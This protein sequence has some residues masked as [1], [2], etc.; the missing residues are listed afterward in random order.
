MMRRGSRDAAVAERVV[1]QG[2]PVPGRDGGSMPSKPTG[3]HTVR[4]SCARSAPPSAVGGVWLPPMPPGGSLQGVRPAGS[5]SGRSR[6]SRSSR[7]HRRR[8]TA[9]RRVRTQGA[10]R[11]ARELLAPVLESTCSVPVMTRRR[12]QARQRAP[13]TQPSVV[14]PGGVGQPSVAAG[15]PQRRRAADR[16]VD[17]CR[18]RRRRASAGKFGC[19]REAEQAA[20]P[21]VV[22]LRPEVGEHGGGR[23]VEAV[24][25]L[26]DAALL[27]D[28]H[29]PVR[30][31]ADRGRR[32]SPESTVSSTKPAGTDAAAPAGSTTPPTTGRPTASRATARTAWRHHRSTPS[33]Q[34]H[35]PCPSPGRSDIRRDRPVSPPRPVL[36]IATLSAKAAGC[37]RAQWYAPAGSGDRSGP[38]RLGH[39]EAEGLA[40]PVA[41]RDL[42]HGYAR[43]DPPPPGRVPERHAARHVPALV[44]R[45]A[46]QLEHLVLRNS[47]HRRQR[48]ADPS[49]GRRASRSTPRGRSSRPLGRAARTRTGRGARRR[50]GRRGDRPTP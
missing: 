19:E 37:E 18:A 23:V 29:P 41:V 30:R 42:V 24:E 33:R 27:G 47:E 11:V 5:R 9:R 8:R 38:E 34:A 15:A 31:E 39:L 4:T 43:R 12:L 16:R 46:E 21:E 17:A 44:G 22:D 13:T 49:P 36:R 28:E 1:G 40:P 3:S 50:S 20:I 7:R 25:H 48:A 6:R 32:A 2:A 14:G 10:D 35:C 45:D 26:D